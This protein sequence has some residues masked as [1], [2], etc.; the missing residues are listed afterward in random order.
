MEAGY[1]ASNR[2]VLSK[3]PARPS[4][5]SSPSDDSDGGVAL[6]PGPDLPSLDKKHKASIL[7]FMLC[8]EWAAERTKEDTEKLALKTCAQF[9]ASVF[10][11]E[12]YQIH[13][14]PDDIRHWYEQFKGSEEDPDRDT[15]YLAQYVSLYLEDRDNFTE[16]TSFARLIE[17]SSDISTSFP[18]LKFADLLLK[19]VNLPLWV[20]WYIQ[21]AYKPNGTPE[22]FVS[23]YWRPGLKADD[24]GIPRYRDH[25]LRQSE[26][27]KLA[28]ATE[29][30]RLLT[31][32]SDYKTLQ[33]LK[34]H[35][36]S[37]PGYPC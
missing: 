19:N 6:P 11:K 28:D 15:W 20:H 29:Y 32:A 2:G 31:E 8:A 35:I 14:H 26:R 3:D 12:V 1:G 16:I 33:E 13:L 24:V 37:M 27:V 23:F 22:K 5:S 21:K 36:G 9:P 18:L 10:S 25:E 17:V 30:E 34:E 7:Y 4:K